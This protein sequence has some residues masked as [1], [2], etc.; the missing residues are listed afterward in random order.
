GADAEQAAVEQSQ[1]LASL[2][3]AHGW[4]ESRCA[5][6]RDALAAWI[7]PVPVKGPGAP[8]TLR[9]TVGPDQVGVEITD[10]SPEVTVVEP[11]SLFPRDLTAENYPGTWGFQLRR[12]EPIVERANRSMWFQLTPDG[13]AADDL[14]AQ[15]R[16]PGSP[17]A[18]EMGATNTPSGTADDNSPDGGRHDQTNF[19]PREPRPWE[20]GNTEKADTADERSRRG[21]SDRVT[22]GPANAAGT[23][24]VTP[25][26][27]PAEVLSP[28][29]RISH[30]HR[31]PPGMRG[32]ADDWVLYDSRPPDESEGHV[33][34]ISLR[35]MNT[36]ARDHELPYNDGSISSGD[37]AEQAGGD[38]QHLP[39]LHHREQMRGVDGSDGDGKPT[40]STWEATLGLSGNVHDERLEAYDAYWAAYL[41]LSSTDAVEE[42]AA[43]QR[44]NGRAHDWISLAVRVASLEYRAAHGGL[45]GGESAELAAARADLIYTGG[46]FA[47]GLVQLARLHGRELED[48]WSARWQ[49]AR[50]AM[51]SVNDLIG[52]PVLAIPHAPGSYIVDEQ[53]LDVAPAPRFHRFV[54][55]A[56]LQGYLS[57]RPGVVTAFWWDVNDHSAAWAKEDG[58][59]VLDLNG[60]RPIDDGGVDLA[61]PRHLSALVFGADGD[62]VLPSDTVDLDAASELVSMLT[63]LKEFG[64]DALAVLTALV[65]GERIEDVHVGW[66]PHR[67]GQLR[68]VL[69]QARPRF[70][71]AGHS[72]WWD[73][74]QEALDEVAD[75]GAI[76]FFQRLRPDGTL[77]VRG[78]VNLD[79]ELWF[80]VN[81]MP[82]SPV[83]NLVL[84][85]VGEALFSE[86][87]K[88][89]GEHVDVLSI[90]GYFP[91]FSTIKDVQASV[92]GRYA[93][94]AGYS[95][96]TLGQLETF[97]VRREVIFT[98]PA[99]AANGETIVR[100]SEPRPNVPRWQ[101]IG[102]WLLRRSDSRRPPP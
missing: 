48:D 17:S 102:G 86:M 27:S 90:N 28:D 14:P 85:S 6:A 31:K 40:S 75:L 81:Q 88:S 82:G 77:D 51:Q 63:G 91:G 92:Y 97:G 23:R 44:V 56:E 93:V 70:V 19:L 71:A 34:L 24:P 96:V 35:M 41:D 33:G 61:A 7:Y 65:D 58:G 46:W 55:L 50:L 15:W 1:L 84:G 22:D 54:R 47:P 62:P 69:D 45:I 79:G 74:L 53:M 10:D 94:D 60:P 89:L 25:W 95:V 3:L 38:G 16:P 37:P 57:R 13:R 11:V 72:D 98:K 64:H 99:P 83:A 59:P 18:V 39:P 87:M 36:G 21:N 66:L 12:P 30:A 52:R 8:R 42:A 80:D 26:S 29:G 2:M 32:I 73:R 49:Q 68:E 43:L 9:V 101:R 20:P 67:Y 76:A 100:P 4:P 5:Q 78:T